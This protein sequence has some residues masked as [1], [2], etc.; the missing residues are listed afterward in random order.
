MARDLSDKFDEVTVS[1]RLNQKS[2][3][4]FAGSS[5]LE[6]VIIT[7]LTLPID[8]AAIM[9]SFILCLAIALYTPHSYAP[10][11]P[12]PCNVRTVS[13]FFTIV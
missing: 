10:R 1:A 6:P 7:A 5:F 12:P 11:A 2:S 4:A 13:I 9:S 8:V 3:S